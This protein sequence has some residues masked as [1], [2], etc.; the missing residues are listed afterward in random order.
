MPVEQILLLIY[1]T[2]LYD[3]FTVLLHLE[4]AAKSKF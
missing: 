1:S 3:I 2:Q 4:H